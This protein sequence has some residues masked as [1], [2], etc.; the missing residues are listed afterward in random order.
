MDEEK[1]VEASGLTEDQERREEFAE[2]PTKAAIDC[3]RF[4]CFVF[5]GARVVL[6]S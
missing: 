1:K 3:G 5:W 4:A 6:F 2:S